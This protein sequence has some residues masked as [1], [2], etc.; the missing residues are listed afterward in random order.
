MQLMVN[1]YWS[2][3]YSECFILIILYHYAECIYAESHYAHNVE[4]HY[5]EC[6]CADCRWIECLCAK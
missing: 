3:V 4:A 1:Q 2:S 5:A 6:H